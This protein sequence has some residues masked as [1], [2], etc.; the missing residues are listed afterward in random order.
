[1]SVTSL[2]KKRKINKDK[3]KKTLIVSSFCRSLGFS[4]RVLLG[5]PFG[6]PKGKRLFVPAIKKNKE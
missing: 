2:K 3:E 6:T 1:V 5:A 4:C